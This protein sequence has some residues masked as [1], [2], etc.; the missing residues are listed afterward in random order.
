MPLLPTY[1]IVPTKL[2]GI[3][4]SSDAPHWVI[5]E[6]LRFRWAAFGDWVP[7]VQTGLPSESRT[8]G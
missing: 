7:F 2:P 6:S 3:A 1:D 5:Y 4:C 8:I